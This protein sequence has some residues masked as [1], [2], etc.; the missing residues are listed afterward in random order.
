VVSYAAIAEEKEV[1]GKVSFVSLLKSQ[2]SPTSSLIPP[3][4]ASQ[5]IEPETKQTSSS[6]LPSGKM[7][8]EIEV[9]DYCDDEIS[10]TYEFISVATKLLGDWLL[11]GIAIAAAFAL[12]YRLG[13]TTRSR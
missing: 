9:E 5:S 6:Q 7:E 8:A 13:T 1:P 10:D 2:A 11:P 4:D 3:A 12:I